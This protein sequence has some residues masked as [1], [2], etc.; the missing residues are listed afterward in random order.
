MWVPEVFTFL[1]FDEMSKKN[2]DA[3]V[4]T[5]SVSDPVLHKKGYTLYKV[6]SKVFPKNSI[7]AETQVTVWKRYNDFKKLHKALFTIHQSLHL[8]D[9]FPPFAK[10]RFF[11]RFDENVIEERRKSAYELLEFAAKHPPLFTSQVF[12][13]F[14]EGGHTPPP[15]FQPSEKKENTSSIL[16]PV[17]D[18]TFKSSAAP[19]FANCGDTCML[20][21]NAECG[22][23]LGGIWKHRQVADDISISSHAT[24]G[25]DDDD[26]RTTFTDDDHSISV[27]PLDLCEFDPLFEVTSETDS[28]LRQDDFCNSWLLSALQSCAQTTSGRPD[29]DCNVASS[30]LEFPRPFGDLEDHDFSRD[31]TLKEQTYSSDHFEVLPEKN[32]TSG[33]FSCADIEEFDPLSPK[34][35]PGSTLTESDTAG[36]FQK[37]PSSPSRII[38]WEGDAYVVKAGK[39]VSEAQEAELMGCY[40][41]AFACYK[42]AIDILLL[43]VQK[44]IQPA[45][46]EA[47]RRKI[48]QYLIRA[49]EIYENH[50]TQDLQPSQ[51]IE[52]NV[53]TS[54]VPSVETKSLTFRGSLE[55]LA[56]FKVLG[57]LHRVLLV[58][59]ISSNRTYVVK[60]LPK[61]PNPVTKDVPNIVPQDI[62]FMVQLYQ[63]Y[64]T[65]YAFFLIL[66][67]A[68][69]GRVWDYVSSYLHRSPM[70]PSHESSQLYSEHKENVYSGKKLRDDGS[71]DD[72]EITAQDGSST[73]KLVPNDD[74]VVSADPDLT[75][76]EKCASSYVA[77]FQTYAA[78]SAS[79]NK[80]SLAKCHS[81][82]QVPE[83]DLPDD[84]LY[85]TD[86]ATIQNDL[87]NALSD[88]HKQQTVVSEDTHIFNGFEG[89]K[90]CAGVQKNINGVV[91]ETDADTEDNILC[92][93]VHGVC[94]S[95]V[96]TDKISSDSCEID[97]MIS[98]SEALIKNVDHTLNCSNIVLCKDHSNCKQKILSGDDEET[99]LPGACENLNNREVA[100]DLS[101]AQGL[102]PTSEEVSE[103]KRNIRSSSLPDDNVFMLSGTKTNVENM[104][105]GISQ[106]TQSE[107]QKKHDNETSSNV[108]KPS[109]R[110]DGRSRLSSSTGS[111][112]ISSSQRVS[113]TELFH[114]M[115][116]SRASSQPVRLPESCIR[117]WAAQ[118]VVALHSLHSLGVIWQDLHPDNLLLGREGD[119]LLT[120][121]SQW[122]CVDQILSSS[123]KENM[124]AAPE[125]GSIFPVTPACDWWSLGAL[126]FELLTGRSLS[127]CHP[128]G[129]TSHTTTS[130]PP[131]ISGEAT[132]LLK[133][134]LKYDAHERLGAGPLGSEEIRAHPFFNSIY[135][136]S[137]IKR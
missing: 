23:S 131:G 5:F 135:W 52:V 92:S 134:L 13:K 70:S 129:I 30:T 56:K 73:L 85:I 98:N 133:K 49:E 111:L 4:R 120:Y 10:A 130:I 11:G 81:E 34:G 67:Y 47:V 68:S 28:S 22:N 121:K 115:D 84:Y 132:D 137:L 72:S 57:V 102:V 39:L 3:W 107:K 41:S 53:P 113:F 24:E 112:E 83:S 59:D 86:D 6:T 60:T 125:V 97:V 104:N 75:P 118:M 21:E 77:L 96:S 36:V 87:L 1:Y 46:K 20:N 48:F 90:S 16:Q 58:L 95:D 25:D 14:F 101:V 110:V 15:D 89:I 35:E 119:I 38:H 88:P 106:K 51:K 62:P 79:E 124:Y 7:E 91:N 12:V 66:E 37:S 76:S 103:G 128:C 55:D 109:H 108:T 105:D 114:Q 32:K 136:E 18:E 27:T 127:S 29:A 126:L 8:K 43:G 17:K 122:N 71:I 45:Q 99:V 82:S 69:G 33:S 40:S 44:D 65:C 63:V 9:I 78:Y 42:S 74:S 19:H 64:E 31:G 50:L 54:P 116:E 94:K 123:S 61:S 2:Y 117:L 100:G 93:T 80:V 26:D